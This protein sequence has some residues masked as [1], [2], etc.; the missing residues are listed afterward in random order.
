M[1]FQQESIFSLS[2]FKGLL[3]HFDI[4]QVFCTFEQV[5]ARDKV[6]LLCVAIFELFDMPVRLQQ[7]ANLLRDLLVLLPM[8]QLG[9]SNR[10]PAV[11]R[12]P[13]A[14]NWAR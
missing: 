10:F 3:S 12:F 13:L 8:L 11:Q 6:Q 4:V 14:R 1:V 9:I 7:S 2:L 5:V